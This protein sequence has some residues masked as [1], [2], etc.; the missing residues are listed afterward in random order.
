MSSAAAE[1]ASALADKPAPELQRQIARVAALPDVARLAVMPDAHPGLSVPNGIAASTMELVYPELVGGDI[2]CGISAIRFDADSSFFRAE[3]AGALLASFRSLVPTIK[4]QNADLAPASTGMSRAEGLSS[5]CLVRRMERD[6][7]Y[8]LGTLGR[9][10]HF[11]ELERDEDDRLWLV[12]HSGSR[13]M[14]RHILEY[15]RGMAEGRRKEGPFSL[16]RGSEL[17]DAYM[18]DAEWACEYARYNRLIIINR[19]ADFLEARDLAR[20]EEWT[21]IDS[22]HNFIRVE[23]I[24]GIEAVVHRKSANSAMLDEIGVIAGS[25]SSGCRIVRGLGNEAFLCSSS[26]GAGRTLS[27]GEA[28]KSIKTREFL[29]SM[30]GIAFDSG[31]ASVLRDEAPQAYRDI[32]AVMRAQRSLARCIAVLRPILN[33]KRI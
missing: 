13:S 2:G 19:I 15:Y 31:K 12:A 8:Q 23:P 24:G 3:D 5:R 21:Y 22:P 14:G 29:R 28:K 4:R 7:L 20:P 25:M 33:D 17:G 30:K 26:H 27:R 18:S 1:I 6:G 11:I 32:E 10:N 9:G 16:R